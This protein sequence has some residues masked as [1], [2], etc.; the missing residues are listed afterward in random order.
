MTESKKNKPPTIPRIPEFHAPVLNRELQTLD[1]LLSGVKNPLRDNRNNSLISS[2]S[3]DDKYDRVFKLV[4]SKLFD[5]SRLGSR[6]IWQG[7]IIRN[8]TNP[9]A[10][11]PAVGTLP[12]TSA[13]GEL[14]SN[15][16]MGVVR[17][18][19][20]ELHGHLPNPENLPDWR[21]LLPGQTEESKRKDL[22]ITE[23]Y[24]RCYAP[25]DYL[26]SEAGNLWTMVMV[27]FPE[28]GIFEEGNI[29]PPQTGEIAIMPG[30][31][32]AGLGVMHSA[33]NSNR[34]PRSWGARLPDTSPLVN[35]NKV[36]KITLQLPP[37]KPRPST[38]QS[39]KPPDV[40]GVYHT[41]VDKELLKY[42]ASC[43]EVDWTG[44][45]GYG[46]L[47]QSPGRPA[48]G[49]KKH[50]IEESSKYLVE[51]PPEYVRP[52][53]KW[54]KKTK[55]STIWKRRQLTHVAVIGPLIAMITQARKDGIPYPILTA[56]STYRS[57]EEQ[58]RNFK[59]YLHNKYGGD[60]AACRKYNGDPDDPRPGRQPPGGDHFA[61]RG[62]DFFLGIDQNKW[63][64]AY[65]KLHGVNRV[66]AN[67]AF[68]RYMHKQNVFKWLKQNAEFFGF[69]NW[70]R[71]P[72]HYAFNPDDREG[73]QDD[74]PEFGAPS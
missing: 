72:W 1:Q 62:V 44:C 20:P 24:P 12:S 45:G 23:L 63:S 15:I 26:R 41:S 57:L 18:F 22:A 40:V 6:K 3:L 32:S 70:T 39:G 14:R 50:Y 59:F 37:P 74:P 54:N 55:K 53:R 11:S 73:R 29:L 16:E 2:L 13:N 38:R 71:E 58:R 33:Q 25:A 27:E 4:D 46:T 5:S 10:G 61:A 64:D 60:Y 34:N 9:E 47:A 21:S 42:T 17:V 52:R 65:G 31:S 36:E 43:G 66:K 30:L 35:L 28:E 19:I 49:K 51:L 48:K 69:Y 56:Y 7:I 68:K 67:Q 8:D